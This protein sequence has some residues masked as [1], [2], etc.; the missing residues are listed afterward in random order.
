ME[1]RS[2]SVSESFLFQLEFLKLEFQ[3]IS[4]IIGRIDN[5]T[6][7]IKKWTIA[8]W[9]GSI[10]LAI[11]NDLKEYVILSVVFPPLFWFIDGWRRRVQRSFI[12]R[13]LKI[14]EFLN[15]ENLTKSFGANRLVNFR[16][17]DP[18]A[19]QYR[20]THEYREFTKITYTMRFKEVGV[21][22]SGLMLLSVALGLFFLLRVN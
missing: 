15:G 4:D 6:E 12:F 19:S 22:Y 9:A 5:M 3:A 16:L 14:S 21:F 10:A 8:L 18:R 2:K 20:D 7:A 13:R 1:E 11:G 17:L